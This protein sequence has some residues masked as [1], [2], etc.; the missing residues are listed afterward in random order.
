MNFRKQVDSR[1]KDL[2][3]HIQEA[4][5]AELKLK[6]YR[7]K[8]KDYKTEGYKKLLDQL[9]SAKTTQNSTDVFL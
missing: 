7:K 5:L 1:I 9:W 3:I 8:S 4:H 2:S 6:E